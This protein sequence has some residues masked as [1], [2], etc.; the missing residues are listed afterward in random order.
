MSCLGVLAAEG[1]IA[2]SVLDGRH[3][4]RAREAD[5][6]VVAVAGAD[7][8]QR[9]DTARDGVGEADGFEQRQ[10]RLVD[11]LELVLAKRLEV[12]AFEAGADRTYVLG[13]GR[14]TQRSSRL[15]PAGT[16]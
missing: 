1:K 6:P 8:L 14:R 9:L 3:D 13:Q 4:Q 2:G 7:A 5:A 12:A 15:A 10:H 11:A 16:A